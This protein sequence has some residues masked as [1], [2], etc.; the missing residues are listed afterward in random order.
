MS[1]E[2]FL[3]LQTQMRQNQSEL[4]EFL[5]DL[6]S[7]TDDVKVK[8]E[9][10]RKQTSDFDKSVRYKLLLVATVVTSCLLQFRFER[11]PV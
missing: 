11:L 1:Q 2:K 7:W 3:E 10:L 5:K 4:Q 6:N 9:R 8:D